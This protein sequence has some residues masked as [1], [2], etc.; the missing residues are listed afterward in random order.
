MRGNVIQRTNF[1][2]SRKK[3]RSFLLSVRNET[4]YS[5]IDKEIYQTIKRTVDEKWRYLI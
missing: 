4:K 3:I 2:L 5:K 1:I